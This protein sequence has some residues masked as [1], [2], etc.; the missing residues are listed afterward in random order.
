MLPVLD[1]A[2]S[3]SGDEG[4]LE[5]EMQ[6]LTWSIVV[7]GMRL[8]ADIC[9]VDIAEAEKYNRLWRPGVQP[10]MLLCALR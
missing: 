9:S 7:P 1:L 6:P 2:G 8:C 3:H 5:K 4:M 10:C